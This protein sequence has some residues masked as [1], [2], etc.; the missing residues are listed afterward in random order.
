MN[1]RSCHLLTYSIGHNNP[2]KGF[3]PAATHSSRHH[4]LLRAP[5]FDD[6]PFLDLILPTDTRP[7]SSLTSADLCI[8]ILSRRSILFNL[9]NIAEPALP[10]GSN[11]LHYVYVVDELLQLTVVSNAE[12]LAPSRTVFKILRRSFLAKSDMSLRYKEA[13]LG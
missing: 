7:F 4:R 5:L 6:R 10:L 8:K 12:I 1:F 13:R 9:N 2:F 3:R 11:T